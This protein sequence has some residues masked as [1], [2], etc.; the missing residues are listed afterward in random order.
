MAPRHG[1][2][3]ARHTIMC[4]RA[5]FGVEQVASYSAYHKTPFERERE[6]DLAKGRFR[7]PVALNNKLLNPI[8]QGSGLKV[9][10]V[11]G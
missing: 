10:D 9:Q 4:C 3:E 8:A 2:Q 7:D 5:C 11:R 6:R 1:S